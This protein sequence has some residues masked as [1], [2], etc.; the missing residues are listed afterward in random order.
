MTGKYSQEYFLSFVYQYK[1]NAIAD[2]IMIMNDN[3]NRFTSLFIL[4]LLIMW[5]SPARMYSQTQSTNTDIYPDTWVGTDAL[6][7]K[8]PTSKEVGTLKTDKKRTVGIFYITWHDEGKYK[9]GIPYKADVTKVLNADPNA[10]KDG[11]NKEWTID[12]YHWGEPE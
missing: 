11:K 3:H 8:M 12:S 2:S 10:R 6:G 1:N 4:G 7:R 5:F 9:I